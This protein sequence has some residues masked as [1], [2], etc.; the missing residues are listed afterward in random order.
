MLNTASAQIDKAQKAG[1]EELATNEFND[2][3]SLLQE[4]LSAPKG[5]QRMMLS[6][7]ANAKARLAESIS[8]QIKS[9][10]EAEKLESELR[11]IEDKAV[12]VRLERQTVEEELKQLEQNDNK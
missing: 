7:R 1:A 9:E 6:E 11:I 10:K 4:A 5:K 8:K 2:A 3:K 12:R